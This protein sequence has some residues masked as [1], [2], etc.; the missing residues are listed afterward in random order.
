MSGGVQWGDAPLRWQEVAQVAR[1]NAPLTLSENAWQRISQGRAIVQHIIDAGQVAYGINTGLG[2]LCNITLAQEQLSQLSRNTLLSHA[3]GVGPLL[4]E[5]Q[6]RAIICAAVANY[7]HGKSGI[8][9]AI[10]EQLLAFLNLR[11]TPQVPSQGS[12]GYLTHMAH[13]GL[14]LMGVGEVSW[15]GRVLPAAQALEEAGLAPI[16]PGAK[17]GL[18][19]VNGTPCMTGLACLALDDAAK[20]L[21]WADVTGAMSFEALRGQT[22]AFDE[23]IL[24]LK[25]S[26]GLQHSGHR[27]RQ[28]LADSQLLAESQGVRTQDALSLRSM[29]QVHG[30]CRDQF[31]HAQR[32]VDTEL[33][34][35]TDNP[36]IIGTLDDWRVVSQAHPHGESVAMACDILAI[37][38]AELGAIAE[39]RLDRLV[40]PLVS[41]LPAFLVTRPGVNSGMMIAQYVAASLCA[42]NKQLAQPAVLDNFVTSAL[43][44]DHLSLGT[45]AALKLHRLNGNLY[46]ILGIEYLLAAQGLEFH[47]IDTL[48]PGTRR[49]LALLRETVP[50]WEDDRWL[51]PEIAKAVATLK[52]HATEEVM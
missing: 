11:I 14:A 9:C 12:V 29:P 51:A 18:S 46:Q 40:N 7:S 36:L 37:A 44:E 47:R 3:C 20:L 13:I 32:Q 28:L 27:L 22:A 49:A 10:V 45:G 6:T 42:E 24:A 25:A 2:A 31:A 35:C 19:L 38:M 16:T 34:A 8:S 41:G 39:R 23:E 5:A 30:A 33:N 52:R 48:A 26:P 21:D 17:E 50:T 43:Q 15:Q 4:D 1:G